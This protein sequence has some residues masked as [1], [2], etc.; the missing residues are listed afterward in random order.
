MA[1]TDAVPPRRVGDEDMAMN[2]AAS[3]TADAPTPPSEPGLGAAVAT[4]AKKADVKLE[5]LFDD[6]ESDDEFPSSRPTEKTET[7]AKGT[8]DVTSPSHTSTGSP[9]NTPPSSD[10]ME[11]DDLGEDDFNVD[12]LKASDP[13]VMR[14]F[15]Q[16]LFPWRYLFQWLN[17]S[18]VP[19][20]DFRHRE[21]AFTLANDAYLRYRSYPSA[22]LYVFFALAAGRRLI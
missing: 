15:Y 22:D 20:N 21:I 2:D 11:V 13:E 4:D 12:D 16:R 6:M 14:T 19:T 17:H 1:D 8:N 10:D 9:I 7:T 5:E 3:E 18:A